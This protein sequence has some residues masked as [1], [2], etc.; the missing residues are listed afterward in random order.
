[1]EAFL[2]VVA[3]SYKIGLPSRLPQIVCP[4]PPFAIV[5]HMEIDD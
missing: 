3:A 1:M 5:E 2:Q 4:K